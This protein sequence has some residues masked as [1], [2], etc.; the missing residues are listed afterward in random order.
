MRE[1]PHQLI[2]IFIIMMAITEEREKPR[3][4]DNEYWVACLGVQMFGGRGIRTG[5]RMNLSRVINLKEGVSPL[6]II[7]VAEQRVNNLP[8]SQRIQRKGHKEAHT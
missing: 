1:D 5:T 2:F 7:L 4:D 8:V 6:M 3:N